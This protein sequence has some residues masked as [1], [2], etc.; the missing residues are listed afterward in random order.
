[1]RNPFRTQMPLIS[2]SN[3]PNTL[4]DEAEQS[5]HANVVTLDDAVYP[6]VTIS[7]VRGN[8]VDTAQAYLPAYAGQ[9]T[10]E[11]FERPGIVYDYAFTAPVDASV[12]VTGTDR[13]NYMH[14]PVTGSAMDNYQEGN[15]QKLATRPPGSNGPVKGGQ[16]FSQVAYAAW[17]HQQ[18]AQYST[19]SAVEAQLAAI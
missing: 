12:H 11:L 17:W 10:R 14:G 1:M 3:A 13:L 19:A 15:V 16:D 6:D 4:G 2:Y 9:D 7:P 8:V 18:M 5:V